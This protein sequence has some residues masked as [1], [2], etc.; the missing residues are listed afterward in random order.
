MTINA[1]GAHAP[2]VAAVSARSSMSPT[3][4]TRLAALFT[5][6]RFLIQSFILFPLH[7]WLFSAF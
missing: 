7:P 6:R 2:R 1:R 3:V 4:S 5:R